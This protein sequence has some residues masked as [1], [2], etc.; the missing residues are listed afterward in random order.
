[1]ASEAWLHT[2][3]VHNNTWHHHAHTRTHIHTHNSTLKHSSIPPPFF[4]YPHLLIAII[5]EILSQAHS[6]E[7]LCD[8]TDFTLQSP[9]SIKALYCTKKAN[10]QKKT[11]SIQKALSCQSICSLCHGEILCL[12]SSWKRSF[13]GWTSA[14]LWFFFS[15]TKDYWWKARLPLVQR[16]C[17]FSKPAACLAAEQTNRQIL[18]FHTSNDDC[19]LS[20]L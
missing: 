11:L 9:K 10:R 2:T 19:R 17:I 3:W 13:Y 15:S 18:R 1:M 7:T 5:C 4:F 20:A 16:T 6:T 8:D 14:P 12:I